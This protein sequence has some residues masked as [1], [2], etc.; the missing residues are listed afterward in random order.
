MRIAFLVTLDYL[1][2]EAEELQYLLEHRRRHSALLRYAPRHLG[3]SL[4]SVHLYRLLAVSEL[5]QLAVDL[6]C[7]ALKFL[8][9]D[10]E[11]LLIIQLL[12]GEDASPVPE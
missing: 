6:R 11:R 12:L 3:R 8:L 10:F 5:I 4:L 9:Q 1:V 7:L 2:L